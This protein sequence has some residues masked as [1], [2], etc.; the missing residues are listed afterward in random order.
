MRV[1]STFVL[2]MA[3]ATFAPPGANPRG[4]AQEPR[5]PVSVSAGYAT[6]ADEWRRW[7]T[8]LDTMVRAGDLVP[9]SRLNDRAVAGRVHEYLAQHVDGIR[10]QGGGVSRQLDAGVTVS[11]FG[12]VYD[13][14]D[15]DTS[16][17]LSAEQAVALLEEATGATL[18]AARPPALVILP[19]SIGAH[20]LTYRLTMSN[21]RTYFVDATS[22]RIVHEVDERRTQASIG[23]GAGILGDR[24]KV[25]ANLVDGRFQAH[26][27]IRPAEIVTLD[28]HMNPFQFFDLISPGPPGVPR[29]TGSDVAAD[30][31]NEWEDS[32]VVDAHAIAG[33]TYDYFAQRHGYDGIDGENGRFFTMVNI[34]PV[35]TAL[36]AGSPFGPEGT[37]IAA[38]GQLP[39]GTAI[40][41]EDVVAHELM[42]GVTHNSVLKRTGV[43]FGFGLPPLETGPTRFELDGRVHTCG[44]AFG[45][46]Q[47]SRRDR[48]ELPLLCRDG[49]FVVASNHGGAL[50]ESYSDIFAAAV[51]FFLHEPGTGPLRADYLVGEDLPEF[52][53]L[54][55]GA[56]GPI[57]SLENPASIPILPPR[58]VNPPVEIGMPDAYRHAIRFFLLDNRPEWIEPTLIAWVAGSAFELATNDRGAEHWNSTLLSHAFYLAIEGGMNRTTG[59]VVGGGGDREQVERA[60]FR[61][62][63]DMMP[64]DADFF[65]AARVIHQSA[66]DLFGP[67]AG[68]TEAIRSAL[69]AV[70]LLP[71]S[72]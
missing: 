16:P 25:S 23:G 27:R 26:D 17:A 40:V 31:D 28:A 37:G 71:P 58:F 11:V 29:W 4:L 15:L 57:R 44:N 56:P 46:S 62:M 3:L 48:L 6:D 8:L 52:G 47:R 59:I 70:D 53:L 63:T 61:A 39:S 1:S 22:G 5:G 72:G 34:G 32:A 13:G 60:F 45:V 7:D 42:H 54:A 69:V 14:I 9:V 64:P 12:T 68:A 24:K 43:P 49:A 51:E 66:V 20:W 33:F 2:A 36:W 10:V 65:V 67:D 19:T 50:H 41:A 18:A 55:K 35:P 21:V 38:F 30:A